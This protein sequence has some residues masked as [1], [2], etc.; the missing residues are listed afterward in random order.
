MHL[1]SIIENPQMTCMDRQS[2]MI[3]DIQPTHTA[4]LN[5]MMTS[6]KKSL[7]LKLNMFSYEESS[8]DAV[9]P[10]INAPAKGGSWITLRK[11]NSPIFTSSKRGVSK[12][13]I[14]NESPKFF[15][16]TGT[17]P[18]KLFP[19]GKRAVKRSHPMMLSWN[20]DRQNKFLLDTEE[21][22]SMTSKLSTIKPDSRLCDEKTFTPQSQTVASRNINLSVDNLDKDLTQE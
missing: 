11:S 22:Y 6:P 19:S 3:N 21:K 18:V 17:K 4:N 9:T 16:E 2:S 15:K 14:N 5:I 13:T 12:E 10:S 7:L 1:R 20:T 8:D